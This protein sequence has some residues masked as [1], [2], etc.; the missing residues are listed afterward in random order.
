[1]AKARYYIETHTHIRTYTC[2]YPAICSSLI[3]SFWVHFHFEYGS[4]CS[5]F[6]DCSRI[7]SDGS[8]VCTF[9]AAL[10]SLLPFA[11]HSM[12]TVRLSLSVCLL[13]CHH[14]RRLFSHALLLLIVIVA[15]DFSE[16]FYSF[17]LFNLVVP[18]FALSLS[19]YPKISFQFALSMALSYVQL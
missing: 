8:N 2:I 7:Y 4:I 3:V 6:S 1:M 14:H 10:L 16:S 11:F 15:T 5:V 17:H 19:F 18:L 12:N 9:L 13:R